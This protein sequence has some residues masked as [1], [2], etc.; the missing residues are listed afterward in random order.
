MFYKGAENTKALTVPRGSTGLDSCE[1]LIYIFIS[2]SGHDL[3]S[4]VS[5]F[6]DTL[7]T[8]YGCFINTELLPSAS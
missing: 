8:A 2:W 7:V 6:E 5:L 4:C 3:A 1:P